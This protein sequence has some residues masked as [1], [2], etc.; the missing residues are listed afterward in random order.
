MNTADRL[1]ALLKEKLNEKNVTSE[2]KTLELL[3]SELRDLGYVPENTQYTI[4][5][6]DTIGMSFPIVSK[7]GHIR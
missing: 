4:P 3:Q 2:I 5:P 6:I 7:I 1:Q